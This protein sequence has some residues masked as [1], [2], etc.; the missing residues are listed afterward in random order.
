MG[1]RGWSRD[2]E[3]KGSLVENWTICS[4]GD[5]GRERARME[6]LDCLDTRATRMFAFSRVDVPP[7]P[8][9]TLA[10]HLAPAPSQIHH[11]RSSRAEQSRADKVEAP[12]TDLDKHIQTHTPLNYNYVTHSPHLPLVDHH[13]VAVVNPTHTLRPSP[14]PSSPSRTHRLAPPLRPSR[15]TPTYRPRPRTRLPQLGNLT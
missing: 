7:S 5:K 1:G 14:H 12:H 9:V 2:K 3:F 15:P 8:L 6:N 13:V 4:P 10:P 11:H